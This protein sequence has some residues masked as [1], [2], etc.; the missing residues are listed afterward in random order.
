MGHN[1]TIELPDEIYAV[2]QRLSPNMGVTVEELAMEWV[3]RY[4][5]SRLQLTEEAQQAAWAHL[6]RHIG[7]E[8][9]GYPTGADNE[10]IDTDFV[11]ESGSTHKEG[12][13]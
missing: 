2:L 13:C 12:T 10:S 1:L 6:Q 5:K 9:L 3:S 4:A 11:R 8:N 7:A